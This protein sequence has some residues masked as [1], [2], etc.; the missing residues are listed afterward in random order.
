MPIDTS[1]PRSR[2]AML[3]AA[4]G[5][6]A[7][8]AAGAVIPRSSATAANGDSLILGSSTNAATA[9]TILSSSTS[10]VVLQVQTDS[11]QGVSGDAILGTA[12]YGNGVV[13]SAPHGVGVYGISPDGIGVDGYSASAIGIRARSGSGLALSVDGR[14]HFNTSGRTWIRAGQAS[15][16]ITQGGTRSTSRVFATLASNRPGRSVRAVVPTTDKFT[17]YMNAAMTSDAVLT[18]WVLD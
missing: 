7:A 6:I 2:R 10:G 11:S 18:W 8:S 12:T 14:V 13:G 5:A 1:S 9:A 17:V 15:V 16:T 4:I 3:A